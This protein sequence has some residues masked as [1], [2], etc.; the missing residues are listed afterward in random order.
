MNWY[1]HYNKNKKILQALTHVSELPVSV[2]KSPGS[3][4]WV[5]YEVQV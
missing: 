3:Q 4:T 5:W 1:A 2:I